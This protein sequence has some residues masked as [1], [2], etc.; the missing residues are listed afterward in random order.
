MEIGLAT[1]R[2]LGFVQ[3]IVTRPVDDPVKAE[4]WDTG[5]SMVIAW[6]TNL[7]SDSIAKSILFLDSTREIWMQLEKRFSLTNGGSIKSTRKYQINKEVYSLKQNHTSVN[8]YYTALRCL[9]EELE[10]MSQLPPLT[11]ISDQI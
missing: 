2:K 8:D 9:W 11:N 6:L 1:K 7:V 10:S 3:G 4:M 5:N